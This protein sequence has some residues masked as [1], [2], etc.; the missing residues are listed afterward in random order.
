M[1][2]LDFLT[3]SWEEEKTLQTLKY[4]T[5]VWQKRQF[6]QLCKRK[7]LA[8]LLEVAHEWTEISSFLLVWLVVA[9][10]VDAFPVVT[11]EFVV[12]VEFGMTTEAIGAVDAAGGVLFVWVG[13][14]FGGLVS[15][16]ACVFFVSA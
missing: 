11:V 3:Q 6:M 15:V 5:L 13:C 9:A 2:H 14:W 7:E 16:G 8:F 4:A 1:E 12:G 10:E